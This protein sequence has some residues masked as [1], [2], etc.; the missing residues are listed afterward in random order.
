MYKK[1]FAEYK[2]Y[3]KYLMHL[4]TDD[5]YTTTEWSAPAYIECDESEAK[6]RGLN[7]EPLKKIYKWKRD[8]EGLHF[9]D[10]SPYQ[11]FLVEKYG[12]NDEPSVNHKEIFF[13]IEIEMG[14]ALTPE[15][16]QSAPKKVTS[17][18]WYYKQEDE[19]KIIILDP[20]QQIQPTTNG[21]KEIIPVYTEEVLLSKFLT[22]M[23]ELDPDILVGYNS[24]YFDIPYLYYRIKNVLGEEMVEYLSPIQKIR[25]K[26]SFTTGEIYDSKQPIEIAGVESLDYMRLHKK[27][28]WEDEPSW[29]LDALGEKY[30]GLNKIEYDGSLDRLFEEDIEKF[31]EYNFRDVEILVE[32]DKKLEYLALTKNLSH[33]GKHNYSE[34]YHNTVTQDGAI[35]AYLLS[36]GIIPPR[37]EQHQVKKKGYA[38][39]YLF[40]PKAGIYMYM[41]DEDLTS[42]Y[43]CIIMSLNIGKE[44]MVGRII[45]STLPENLNYRPYQDQDGIPIPS[46]NNY[47]GLND[48]KK[49]D[50]KE[51]LTIE[52]AKGKRTQIEVGA[53]IN[54]IEDMELSVSANGT[55]FRTD[56]KS[57]LSIILNKWFDERV[58]YKNQMKKAYK[59]GNAE[60]GASFYLKQH[61]MKILLNSLYG[62][63]ALPSFRYA[64]NQ[65]I[66]SEAITL[67]GWRII[68]ES[69]LAANRHINKLMKT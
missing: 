11:N 55:F 49:K 52:N 23:R 67:S 26:R 21:N 1:C 9:H 47:L 59:A 43:P 29:K 7:N 19:W 61:T 33:K 6:Y 27:Y 3:N 24:D 53:L 10:M 41:F 5:D 44:T 54:L 17:I 51:K 56:K 63:T 42:L 60:L 37:K 30:A 25:E 12:T 20:K 31:I 62:A 8:M 45:S 36:Q 15:Y 66:L 40:C 48:L 58:K 18:A 14:D 50:P 57:V 69:A 38:G 34:V 39:G 16:I 2:S 35:S 46:R 22:Y 4:W 65:A 32:L 13:D 64:M 28:S 68:Q